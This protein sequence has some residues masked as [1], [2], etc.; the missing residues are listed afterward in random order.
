MRDLVAGALVRWSSA[1]GSPMGVVVE[2]DGPR[3][4]VRFDG[5]A[6]SKSSMPT[7]ALSSE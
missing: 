6:E 7:P 3:I 4:R 2:V 5:E 1:P